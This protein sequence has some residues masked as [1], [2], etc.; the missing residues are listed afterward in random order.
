MSGAVA[1]FV[2]LGS[3]EGD[4]LGALRG[5]V[6][7]LAALRDTEVVGAS[8]V[9]ETEAH[10]LPG[11][12][13]QPDHFNAVVRLE[14]RLGP[15][16]LL[17]HLH[18]IERAAGRDPSAPKWSPRPLDLDLL[19]YGEA[20]IRAG[21]LAVPHPRIGVRRFVLQPLADLASDRQV[22]GLGATVRD[23][24]LDT[25]DTASV[26]RVTHRLDDLLRIG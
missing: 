4:R 15:R 17:R 18:R 8:P 12:G 11:T 16:V 23:L 5:A 10:V 6:R 9:Y 22:P 14:T 20:R 13:P 21:D 7:A 3:N 19:L 25:P 1:V 24:L 26:R 2:G